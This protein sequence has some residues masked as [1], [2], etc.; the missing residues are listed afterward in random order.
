MI[1]MKVYKSRELM[2]VMVWFLPGGFEWGASESYDAK[3]LMDEDVVLVTFNYRMGALGNGKLKYT[4][5]LQDGYCF[6]TF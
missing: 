5:C 4:L 2:P 6:R 3:Y 1:E